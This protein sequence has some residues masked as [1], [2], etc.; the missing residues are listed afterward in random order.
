MSDSRGIGPI[1]GAEVTLERLSSG[2]VRTL[3]LED[4]RALED[5]FREFR[6]LEEAI[7]DLCAA[8]GTAT[9]ALWRRRINEAKAQRTAAS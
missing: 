5:A 1:R 9:A 2:A 8:S 4:R 3:T 6:H 7:L